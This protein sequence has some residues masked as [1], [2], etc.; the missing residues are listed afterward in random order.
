MKKL[1]S[2]MV[3]ATLMLTSGCGLNEIRFEDV[4]PQIDPYKVRIYSDIFQESATKVTTAG[5]CTGDEVGVY[6]VNY[7]GETQGVL[8]IEGNQADNVKF[9][10]NEN[11]E[12]ISEYDIYYKD[13][14]T[15]VDFYGY[16]PYAEPTS[17]EA[18]QFEV[19]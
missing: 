7:N 19:A 18:Y 8:K 15:N 11:G 10:Y 6:L 9:K 5:F 16:Y 14:E 1:F 12:W 3:M 13:N 4:L 2:F 17:V